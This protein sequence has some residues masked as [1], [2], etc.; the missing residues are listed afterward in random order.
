MMLFR[1]VLVLTAFSIPVVFCAPNPPSINSVEN[2]EGGNLIIAPNTWLEVDGLNLS[3]A[4]DSRS[5][6]PSD[7]VNGQMPTILDGVSV[8]VNGKN[9]FVY[10]ISPT[11]VNI[12]TP[13]D[14]MQG[15]V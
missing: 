15:T 2:A 7:F 6:L 10:Y 9:A 12:L 3:K 4:G 13:P 14:A 1:R 5:W 8:T 11:Q